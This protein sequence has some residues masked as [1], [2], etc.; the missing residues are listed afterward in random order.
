MNLELTEEQ[1]MIIGMVRK[2]V[3]EEILPLEL[4]LDPDAD[5]LERDDRE[6]LIEK[7]KAMGLYGLDIPPEYGGPEIDLVT[8]TLMAVEMSQ[9]RA[10]LYSPCYG[11]FGGAGLALLFD[12]TDSQKEKYLYPTLRGEK[13]GFFGLSEPSGGSDPARAIQTKAVR[14]GDDWVIN[15]S[16]LWISGADRANFGL[17]FARTDSDKGRNGVTCFIVDTDTPVSYTHLTL[18]TKRIV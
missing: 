13:R 17:V 6:R 11:T 18:P 10:G 8:R 5:E 12:A 2:F 7:T 9:H 16:K 15:G 14:E 3:R 4:D 1:D